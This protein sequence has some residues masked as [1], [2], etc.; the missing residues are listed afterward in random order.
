[1][2]W[3]VKTVGGGPKDVSEFLGTLGKEEATAAHI[4]PSSM[5]SVF[6]IFY[7][8]HVAGDTTRRVGNDPPSHASLKSVQVHAPAV[9]V[10]VGV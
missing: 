2:Q 3:D 4:V 8:R 7:P 1:M 5:T 9:P 6:Y 10:R